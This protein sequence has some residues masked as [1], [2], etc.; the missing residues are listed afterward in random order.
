MVYRAEDQGGSVR[1]ESPEPQFELPE[2]LNLDGSDDQDQ[3]DQGDEGE[4]E[5]IPEQMQTDLPA[6][7][8]QQDDAGEDSGL[9]EHEGQGEDSQNE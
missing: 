3:H 8:A 2:D 9:S 4:D 6:T 5:Q 1:L 7:E